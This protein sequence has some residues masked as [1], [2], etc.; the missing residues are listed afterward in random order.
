MAEVVETGEPYKGYQEIGGQRYFSAVYPD[1][2][3]AE[4]CVSCH[5]NHPVHQERDPDKQFE[6]GDV[7]GGIVINLPVKDG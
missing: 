6:M 4:A 1:E 2:A 3:V 7:M 5:N